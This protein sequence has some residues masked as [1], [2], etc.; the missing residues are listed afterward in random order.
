MI[1]VFLV[2]LLYAICITPVYIRASR[3]CDREG[4]KALNM[5]SG[6]IAVLFLI[7]FLITLQ[8]HPCGYSA[9]GGSFFL[10]FRLLFA[11]VFASAHRQFSEQ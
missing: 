2:P 1:E 11:W 7:F 5:V 4:I 9:G 10:L 3:K 6:T 8:N